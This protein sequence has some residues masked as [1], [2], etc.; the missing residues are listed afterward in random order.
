M[1]SALK[2]KSRYAYL[3]ISLLII[4]GSSV[5]ILFMKSQSNAGST[6]NISGK[7]R[8][9]I[10]RLALLSNNYYYES[11]KESI[12][13]KII[14]LLQDLQKN[15]DYIKALESPI[16]DSIL[17]GSGY[18]YD[19]LLTQ[20]E[21]NVKK[22][23]NTPNPKLLKIINYT[24]ESLL[25]VTNTL[26]TL[27]A[28]ENDSKIQLVINLFIATTLFLLLVIYF[29]YKKVTL[30][31][32]EETEK[33]INE[34]DRQKSFM[35]TILEHSGHSIIAT[36]L[37]GVITLF[38][39]KAQD[40]LG[41]SQDEVLFKQT[42]ALFH[43]EEEVV[44]H[45][46]RLSQEFGVEIEPGFRVFVEKSIRGF[47][48]TNEWTYIKKDGGHII[49]RLSV[50][51][52]KDPD[53]AITGYLGIAEDITELKK[54]ELKTKEYVNLI[55]KNIITSSTNLNGMIIYISEAFCKI[56]GYTKDELLGQNHSIVRHPDMPKELYEDLWQHLLND[57][58]WTGEIKNRKKDGG[59]YW[60]KAN[61]S[62]TYD[63][64]GNKIGYTA[65]RQDITDKKL[66]EKISITD[67]LTD[68]YNR[69]HFDT[70][71]PKML[72]NSKR[73]KEYISFLI[74]DVDHFK[75]YND[76]YGHQMG[77]KV[78]IAIAKT[79]KS[80]LKREDDFC[81][82]L[83]G[84]EFGVVFNTDNKEEALYYSNQIKNNI[85]EMHIEHANNSAS[86]YVTASMRLICLRRDE[87]ENEDLIYKEA[88]A[89][90]Y[91]AKE[92]G[93]NT[94]VIKD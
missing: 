20:Y 93:R 64:Y 11:K 32:I 73:S 89:L 91:K 22:F 7:Q 46:K 23:I 63:L 78:L 28:H 12:K 60:V 79:L 34:L 76:T 18:Q 72:Q 88:D 15:Q 83:G 3:V 68:I 92:Q 4:L 44:R 21:D 53:S 59:Y 75:Q 10:E 48:D 58:E 25:N 50:T 54:D 69:R 42:P 52:L 80:S 47:S 51:A 16:A 61:I 24:N 55:D 17:Y 5:I 49:V 41:Y 8:M 38:N 87:V 82:R 26:V 86:D 29:V 66:V 94:V 67:G 45:A 39:K 56:S 77:D 19:T 14:L 85:E 57:Q 2:S 43:L 84:E 35:S 30:V 62:P 13:K 31:S 37:D 65:I 90:L 81:F 70:I 1:T 71:F 40:L 27:L 33:N 36:D 74:M 9:I 6:I